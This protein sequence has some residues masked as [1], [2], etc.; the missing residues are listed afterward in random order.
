MATSFIQQGLGCRGQGC[1]GGRG[2][3]RPGE[4]C[5]EKLAGQELRFFVLG[6]ANKAAEQ[7]APIAGAKAGKL[8]SILNGKTWACFGH[9]DK[10]LLVGL[11]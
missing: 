11:N 10:Y 1:L 9:E 8:G 7:S 3:R 2:A 4:G 5:S 6:G